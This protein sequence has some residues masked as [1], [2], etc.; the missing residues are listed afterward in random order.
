MH[1]FIFG[2]KVA[3][4]KAGLETQGHEKGGAGG[5][6]GRG[7]HVLGRQLDQSLQSA[8]RQNPPT[9]PLRCTAEEK[10]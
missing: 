8:A 6:E 2:S 1:G 4:T 3:L 9:Q 5:Q 7:L 10:K